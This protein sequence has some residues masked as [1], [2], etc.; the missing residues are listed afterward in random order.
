MIN[1]SFSGS[2]PENFRDNPKL[3]DGN[4]AV[5]PSSAITL[6]DFRDNPKLGDGN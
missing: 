4:I 6:T 3:G 2:K 1:S 5:L